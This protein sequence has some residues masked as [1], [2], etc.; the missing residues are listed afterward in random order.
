MSL[1]LE[2][3][4]INLVDIF[5]AGG[6]SCKPTTFRYNLQ[7]ANRS[8]IAGGPGKLGG[9]G[10][11]CQ[12]RSLDG[13]RRE[14][15]ETCLL[16]WRSR[17]VNSCVIWRAKFLGQVAVVLARVF[18]R[19][20]SNFGSQQIHDRAIFV[21]RPHCSVAAQKTCARTLLSSETVRAV[22]QSGH[23]PLETDRH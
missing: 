12:V 10:L 6:P 2:A 4:R 21:C 17:C 1:T 16:F 14:S 8:L 18:A 3:F 22:H 19:A 7:P 23:E 13:V 15:L 5:R 11:A 20:G 9:D